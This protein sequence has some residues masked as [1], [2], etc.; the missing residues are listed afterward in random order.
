MNTSAQTLDTNGKPIPGLFQCGELA[1][2]AN[3]GGA[4][5]IGGLANTSCI[6]WGKIAGTNAA[7]YALSG[8]IVEK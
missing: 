7:S 5:N 4:A 6:V 3:V 8:T 2:G 1:G